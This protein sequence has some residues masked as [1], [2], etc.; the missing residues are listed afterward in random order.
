MHRSFISF[1]CVLYNLLLITFR[2]TL[3]LSQDIV[4]LT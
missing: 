1:H 2:I 4:L 3:T